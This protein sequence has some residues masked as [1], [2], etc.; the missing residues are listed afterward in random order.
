MI[1]TFVSLLIITQT[2]TSVTPTVWWWSEKGNDPK[3]RKGL[4]VSVIRL[5][6]DIHRGFLSFSLS[7]DIS[8]KKKR[9]RTT[10]KNRKSW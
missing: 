4:D 2:K 9:C 10:K 7:L 1:L 3:R 5:A 6:R 8:R